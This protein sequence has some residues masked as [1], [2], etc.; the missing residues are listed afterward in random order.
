MDRDRIRTLLL[1]VWGEQAC[2]NPAHWPDAL[3]R[4]RVARPNLR[5]SITPWIEHAVATIGAQLDAGKQL[6]GE[7]VWCAFPKLDRARC[8]Q[9]VALLGSEK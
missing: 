4:L 9:L 1:Q 8:V 2:Q 5:G 7:D 3:A 6:T